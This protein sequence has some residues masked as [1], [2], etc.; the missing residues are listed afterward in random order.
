VAGRDRAKPAR[1]EAAVSVLAIED[2]E[3]GRRLIATMLESF[4]ADCTAVGSAEEAEEAARGARFDVVLLDLHLPDC[5][6]A[7]LAARLA[8]LPGTRGTPVI[9]V[10]GQPRPAMMPAVFEDWLEKPYSA[11]ELY[12]AVAGSL[13]RPAMARA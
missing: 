12:A 10:T 4:G 3:I 11:R 9:A 7:D 5:R 8:T 1:G 6:G 2:H 13:A